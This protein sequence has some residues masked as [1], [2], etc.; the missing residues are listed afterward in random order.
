[1]RTR[2]KA[3]AA[4]AAAL[5]ATLA[6]GACGASEIDIAKASKFID[7]AVSKQVG[8]EVKSVKCP[9][10]VKVKAKDTFTC[11]VTGSDGTKGDAKLTQKDDKGNL[12]FYAPFLHTR[13]AEQV[14]QRQLRNRSRGSRGVTVSCPEIIVVGKGRNFDCELRNGTDTLTVAARQ[15]NDRGNFTYRVTD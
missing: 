12:T 2:V 3:A 7:S 11:V 9:E 10:S 13:E 8:A 1:M 15:T 6:L 14:M 5:L 4:V